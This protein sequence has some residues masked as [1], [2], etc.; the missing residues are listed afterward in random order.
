MQHVAGWLEKLG[1]GQYAR[2]FAEKEITV[3][4]LPD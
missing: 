4:I 3:S 1:L 2:R